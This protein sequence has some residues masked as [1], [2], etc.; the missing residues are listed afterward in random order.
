M[1]ENKKLH[2]ETKY[3]KRNNAILRTSGRLLRYCR[4][5]TPLPSN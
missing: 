2:K 3:E 1:D 4:C 5:Y